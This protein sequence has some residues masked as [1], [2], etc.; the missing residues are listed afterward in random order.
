MIRAGGILIMLMP[1]QAST[2][3]ICYEEWTGSGKHRVCCLKCGH[4]FG[5]RCV[6]RRYDAV[7]AYPLLTKR[8]CITEWLSNAANQ[9]CPQCNAKAKVKDIRLLFTSVWWLWS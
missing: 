8:R 9:R 2:C 3:S 6:R 1:W 7:L 4:L 5:K